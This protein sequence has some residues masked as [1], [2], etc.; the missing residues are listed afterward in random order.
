MGHKNAP[1]RG[2]MVD[3]MRLVTSRKGA[4][5]AN[6]ISRHWYRR[7]GCTPHAPV[8]RKVRR[9]L[10]RQPHFVE[11]QCCVGA[12]IF[13]QE[14]V[15]RESERFRG[16]CRPEK[17]SVLPNTPTCRPLSLYNRLYTLFQPTLEGGGRGSS[18]S[19]TLP[20]SCLRAP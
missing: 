6:A 18:L 7:R 3:R 1:R 5:K 12:V 8:Q 9:H 2:E 19:T 17:S 13:V 14:T 4:K 16:S 10:R 15:V 11:R 20:R